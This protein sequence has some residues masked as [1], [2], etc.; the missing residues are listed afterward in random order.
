VALLLDQHVN[1]PVDV[2]ETLMQGVADHV[3]KTGRNDPAGWTSADERAVLKAYLL[4]RRKTTMTDSDLRAKRTAAHLWR[5]ALSDKR[6]S[7]RP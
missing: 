3:G 2:P 7:F 1:R 4:R 5:R 6:G